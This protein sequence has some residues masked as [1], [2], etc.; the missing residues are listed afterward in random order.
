MSKY[1]LQQEEKDSFLAHQREVDERRI[2]DASHTLASSPLRQQPPRQ[3]PQPQQAEVT[4]VS[5][6]HQNVDSHHS[7]STSTVPRAPAPFPAAS[8]VPSS[9]YLLSGLATP[10]Q[11]AASTVPR[12][13]SAYLKE[14]LLS[15]HIPSART[16]TESNT[17]HPLSSQSHLK[18]EL[19]QLD[20]EIG[21]CVRFFTVLLVC[22]PDVYFYYCLHRA[23]EREVGQSGDVAFSTDFERSVGCACTSLSSVVGLVA[24]VC[25]SYFT[26]RYCNSKIGASNQRVIHFSVPAVRC[27]EPC[28][29]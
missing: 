28:G 26:F 19:S 7:T 3:Q 8:S 17:N 12:P 24:P 29:L 4:D 11:T 25:L 6:G 13:Q 16:S 1:S 21:K 15:S 18:A 5:P 9:D 27:A 2:L 14:V 22:R 23:I 20:V 10:A